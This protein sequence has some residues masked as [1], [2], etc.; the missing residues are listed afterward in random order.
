MDGCVERVMCDLRILNRE[1]ARVPILWKR[2]ASR[3]STCDITCWYYIQNSTQVVFAQFFVNTVL[4]LWSVVQIQHSSSHLQCLEW[5]LCALVL[6]ISW[7]KSTFKNNLQARLTSKT[8][9]YIC[10]RN[11]R[12]FGRHCFEPNMLFNVTG[13]RSDSPLVLNSAICWAHGYNW[14]SKSWNCVSTFSWT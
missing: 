2:P 7:I 8:K 13:K 14:K 9:F 3:L 5:G 10:L 1:A 11:P 4:M 12:Q 6:C